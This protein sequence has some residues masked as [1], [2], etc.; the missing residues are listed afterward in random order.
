MPTRWDRER[1]DYSAPIE[2]V[3]RP[4]Y[5]M[6]P[7]PTRA[8]QLAR[9]VTCLSRERIEAWRG[10]ADADNLIESTLV[11]RI[12]DHPPA[13]KH[14]PR[15]PDES[16]I[17]RTERALVERAHHAGF[18]SETGELELMAQLRHHG[19]ATRLLDATRNAY[20]A[21]WFACRQHVE[22][23]GLLIGFRL[24]EEHDALAVNTEMLSWDMDRL[25]A[26]GD[27]RLLWWQ[28]RELS[29]R[30]RAQQALLVFGATVSPAPNPDA[31]P[32]W[33]SVRFGKRPILLPDRRPV[34][35]VDGAAVV[36]ITA[37][38]K[39]AMKSSWP[40]VFGYSDEVLFPDFDGFAQAHR[41]GIE[42]PPDFSPPR[43]S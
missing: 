27:G 19:A 4:P 20:V 35:D 33:G 30:I 34:G 21:V 11:R 23:D 43:N 13:R 32:Y 2:A 1:A 41:E 31:R 15:V 8:D 18:R 7:A 22:K 12:R 39:R 28:P 26:Q 10:Q 9:V 6:V 42:F 5:G 3:L 37:A 40:T 36:L 29:Q 14:A 17:R 24:R 25:L 16:D 38:L